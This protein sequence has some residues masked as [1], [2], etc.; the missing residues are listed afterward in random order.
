[1][2]GIGLSWNFERYVV[3]AEAEE[4]FAVLREADL[5]ANLGQLPV[6]GRLAF[7]GVGVR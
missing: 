4:V 2:H 3:V 5:L 1:L 7:P 6:S